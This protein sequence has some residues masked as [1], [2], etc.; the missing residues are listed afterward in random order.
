MVRHSADGKYV[1]LLQRAQRFRARGNRQSSASKV[2]QRQNTQQ[3]RYFFFKWRCLPIAFVFYCP[4]RLVAMARRFPRRSCRL[5]LH[6]HIKPRARPPAPPVNVGKAQPCIRTSFP[7]PPPDTSLV[8]SLP[9]SVV[10][11]RT[12][13]TQAGPFKCGEHNCTSAKQ[14]CDV[15]RQT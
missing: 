14:C 1:Q 8:C 15:D 6:W 13:E 10:V 3:V 12:G 7:F 9:L 4:R 5:W 2:A 11:T